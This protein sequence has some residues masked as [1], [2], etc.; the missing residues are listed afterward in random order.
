MDVIMTI[1]V[2][3][4]LVAAGVAIWFGMK[5]QKAQPKPREGD[6]GWNDPV[7]PGDKADHTPDG[8]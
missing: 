1:T 8:R 3:V 2:L 7:S 6:T 5:A 4:L